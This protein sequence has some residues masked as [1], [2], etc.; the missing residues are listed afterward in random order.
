MR[1]WTIEMKP[2]STLCDA[3][4]GLVNDAYRA[5]R[6]RGVESITARALSSSSAPAGLAFALGDCPESALAMELA[7]LWRNMSK[8]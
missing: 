2:K 7:K 1:T 4:S 3:I 6:I 8:L 5:P